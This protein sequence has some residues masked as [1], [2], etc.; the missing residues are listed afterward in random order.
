VREETPRVAR[1]LNCFIWTHPVRV[2]M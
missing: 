2:A 1:E